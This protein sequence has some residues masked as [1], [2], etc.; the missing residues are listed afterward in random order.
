MHTCARTHL[1]ANCAWATWRRPQNRVNTKI[2]SEKDVIRSY[3]S[4]TA[5]Y[6]SLSTGNKR[7]L[8]S[9]APST[10]CFNVAQAT[11][12]KRQKISFSIPATGK[13]RSH[14][15][16][17]LVHTASSFSCCRNCLTYL[18]SNTFPCWLPHFM[19]QLFLS[20]DLDLMEKIKWKHRLCAEKA[21]CADGKNKRLSSPNYK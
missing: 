6:S 4:G 8:M 14:V 2:Q 16:P 19:L 10:C 12:Q 11:W 5:K 21:G 15:S 20:R 13:S 18:P 7:V 3:S 17:F 1:Y 9:F